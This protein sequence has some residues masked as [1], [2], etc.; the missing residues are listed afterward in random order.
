[1][2]RFPVRSAN[3]LEVGYDLDRRLLE[4]VFRADPRWIYTYRRVT[5]M[6][7]VQLITAVSVGSFF[8]EEIRSR[9]RKHPYS[10]RRKG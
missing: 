8:S 2:N 6:K 3:L 7:F 1:M 9:P 5:V 4:V 10:K